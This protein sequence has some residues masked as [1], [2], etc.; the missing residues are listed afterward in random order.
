M[1]ASKP[2]AAPKS[3]VSTED[4]KGAWGGAMGAIG[5]V[6]DNTIPNDVWNMYSNELMSPTPYGYNPAQTVQQGQ[7]WSSQAPEM[8][9]AGRHILGQGMDPQNELYNRTQNQVEQQTRAAQAQRGIQTTPYGASA[10][11]GVMSDFNIDWQNA[12]LQRMLQAI[13]GGATAFQSGGQ[14]IA[15]GEGIAA[16]AP[17]NMAT[18]AN[19][20]QQLGMQTNLPEQWQAGAYANLFGAGS[21]AQSSNYQNQV[22]AWKAKEDADAAFWGGIGKLGGTAISTFA[23]MPM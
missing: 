14:A 20:L 6:A 17:Q 9:A 15:G 16:G 22:A 10:E 8:F 23:G 18:Y 21:G 2:P 3:P 12:Q 7:L 19:S 11:G 13:Q 5:G 4:L 1:G